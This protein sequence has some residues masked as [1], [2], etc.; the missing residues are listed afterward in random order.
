MLNTEC[1]K[2]GYSYLGKQQGSDLISQAKPIYQRDG[3][4]MCLCDVGHVC[5]T[6]QNSGNMAVVEQQWVILWLGFT[7][8]WG[9]CWIAA[10][11]RLR[12]RECLSLPKVYWGLNICARSSC[13]RPTDLMCPG[14]GI[15]GSG[16]MGLYSQRKRGGGWG[17]GCESGV[18]GGGTAIWM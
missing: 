8:T 18:L 6:I 15:L 16:E 10:V 14:G 13:V 2:L 17:T 1:Q 4:H 11:G 12:E 9:L 5:V 7:M 3:S